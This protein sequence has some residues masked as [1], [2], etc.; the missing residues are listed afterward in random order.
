MILTVIPIVDTHSR[1]PTSDVGEEINEEMYIMKLK[2]FL[3]ST[4]AL[5][6]A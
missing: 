2:R 4:L 3:Y 6:A 1:N 5:L